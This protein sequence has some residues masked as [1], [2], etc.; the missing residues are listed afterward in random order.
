MENKHFEHQDDVKGFSS[1]IGFALFVPYG[2]QFRSKVLP[3]HQFFELRRRISARIQLSKTNLPIQK[4]GLHHV[5]SLCS[6]F[7]RRT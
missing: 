5:L 2:F 6:D 7:D 1:G 3:V 4:Y